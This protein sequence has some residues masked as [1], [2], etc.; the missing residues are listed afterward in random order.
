MPGGPDSFLHSVPDTQFVHPE[1]PG[2]PHW[3]F[4]FT[5]QTVGVVTGAVLVVDGVLEDVLKVVGVL[6][7]VVVGGV[8]GL[9]GLGAHS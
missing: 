2:P 8:G 5:V 4:S 1:W 3:T 7:E 9:G 6:D